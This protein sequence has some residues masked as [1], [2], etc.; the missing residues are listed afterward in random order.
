MDN[1]FP[2]L[3][4]KALEQSCLSYLFSQSFC[5]PQDQQNAEAS[6]DRV[7]HPYFN[8]RLHLLSS[9]ADVHTLT[10]TLTVMWLTRPSSQRRV[11]LYLCVKRPSCIL[12]HAGMKNFH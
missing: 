8:N 10:L 3:G 1:V 2:A 11:L 9:G 6:S 4:T 7:R 5:C 12:G